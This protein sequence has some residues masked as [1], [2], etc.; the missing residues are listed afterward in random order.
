MKTTN[1]RKLVFLWAI[2]SL[3]LSQVA[4]GQERRVS[5]K[6]IGTD[7]NL[8][9]PGVSVSVKGNQKGTS[10]D[11]NGQFVITAKTGDI[12]V[13]RAI[14]F[15]SQEK[16]VGEASIINVAL[17]SETSALDEVMK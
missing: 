17:K 3:I 9:I 4:Y 14:G 12:L 10:T 11:V 8:P 2:F 5:G 1:K 13:F 6:V 7:D 15:Q 16:P